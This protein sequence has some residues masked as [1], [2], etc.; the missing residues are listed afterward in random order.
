MQYPPPF[1]LVP[2]TA[3][4]SAPPVAP[5]PPLPPLLRLTRLEAH[6]CSYAKDNM[7]TPYTG[8]N[9]NEHL[10]QV[11]W[12]VRLNSA[13][14]SHLELTELILTNNGVIRDI[15][16]TLSRLH[17][18][19]SLKITTC[20]GKVFTRRE[21]E[22]FFFSCPPSLVKCHIANTLHIT[23]TTEGN[24]DPIMGQ[25]WDYDQGPLVLRTTPLLH[26][27]SLRVP[28]M[29]RSELA[30]VL[31]SL[32]QHC[33]S[34]EHLQLPFF[35]NTA[36]GLQPVIESLAQQCSYISSLT[37]RSGCLG[38]YLPRIMELL[39]AQSLKT[40]FCRHYHDPDSERMIAAISRH[41][42]SLRRVEL[43]H[44]TR[45]G[46]TA[47]QAVLTACRT[48]EVFRVHGRQ[49][50]VNTASIS[51]A[52]AVEQDW[53]CTLLR[54][55]TI[56]VWITPDVCAFKHLIDDPSKKSWTED[57]LRHWEELGRFYTQIG[58]LTQL[59][60]LNLKA[61]QQP[62][63]IEPNVF[64]SPYE[65]CL[66]GLLALEDSS[67][68]NGQIGYLSKLSGLNKLRE[69]RGSFVWTNKET[70][71]RIGEREIDWFAN[72][73]PALRI[74]TFVPR[75]DEDARVSSFAGSGSSCRRIEELCQLLE[76]KRP[77]LQ[78][79]FQ[80]TSSELIVTQEG[81]DG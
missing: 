9:H 54:E 76:S 31:Q 36:K 1:S 53:V 37:F 23:R 5:F 63:I 13:T 33:P 72:N 57:E 43:T 14:L 49:S 3:T 56:P 18:L 66:P 44:C 77:E 78:I 51:L 58:S 24:L 38:E 20:S 34:L 45:V 10:H 32:I 71:A 30:S 67:S 55:L 74:A 50:Q 69:L 17:R 52:H 80:E 48:L 64:L 25:D 8:Y 15:A 21:F 47:I 2:L 6:I 42:T 4:S 41:S 73:L 59:E 28:T 61:I 39:P 79:R 29:P 81:W 62:N 75:E 26:L 46:S 27:K 35:D 12:L 7:L 68:T 60:V 70:K 22:T 40:L 65:M 19:E 16:R 11:L